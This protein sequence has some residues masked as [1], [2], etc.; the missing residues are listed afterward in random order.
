MQLKIDPGEFKVY[1]QQALD[2][3]HVPGAAVAVIHEGELILCE[4]YGLR[5]L[6]K[7]LVVTPE[8]L[9]PIASCTKAFTSMC[10][11]L[12]IEE[13]KL[14]WD[15]PLRQY[16]P[17]FKLNESFIT[18]HVTPRDL[19]CHR[20]G[21]PRHDMIWYASNFNRREI[22]DRLQFLELSK[23]LRSAF[24]YNN[25]MYMT[26]GWLVQ[27]LTG[28]SWEIFVQKRIFDVL[29]MNRSNT[30]SAQTQQDENHSQPYMYRRGVQKEIPFYEADGDKVATG[31]AG[32]IVSCVKDLA[33]WLQVYIHE[34]KAGGIQLVS[35]NQLHEMHK[36]HMFVDDPQGQKR[37]G[38]EFSSYGLGWGLQDYKGQVLVQHG[39]AIVGFGSLVS[40]MPRHKL[41]VVVLSNGD[42]VHNS[43]PEAVTLELFDRWLGFEKTDWNSKYKEL[44]DEV[45]AADDR[46][47]A[48]SV[49]QRR[50]IPPSHPIEAFLGDYNHPGYGVI[51]IRKAGEELEL[52]MNNKI[53]MSLEP[54]H[55]DIFEATFE[56]QDMH[57]K[58]SFTTDLQGNIAGFST[59]IEPMVKDAFFKRLPDS[60]L[61]D[62]EF[63]LRFI[64]EY[65]LMGDRLLIVIKDGKL[66]ASL[67]GQEHEL[68]P[69]QGTEFHIK[70][71]VGF[72]ITFLM[73]D[74]GTCIQANLNQ[75]GSVFV[76]KRLMKENN[77]PIHKK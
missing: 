43:L 65:D 46:G 6:E 10:L 59:Q 23:D 68:V 25:L 57:S 13:G 12:L 69:Y 70:E 9:F 26:A 58:L 8:T 16:L 35:P 66:F 49:E 15:K 37:F 47:K 33:L 1:I 32:T 53:H 24:Q 34:G 31:P 11:A 77:Q 64:G 42:R 71:M 54:Y 2:L 30:S 56:S 7:N 40:F 55:Y 22:F 21:L 73:D 60:N 52:V 75:P 51:S 27:E 50:S 45:L 18:E 28:M 39:G 74:R 5:N 3:W 62:P 4:G 36:P 41:G 63:L 19:L 44:T 76:A 48:Q 67:P 61:S 14:D 17:T 20:T 29:G 72:G 38:F